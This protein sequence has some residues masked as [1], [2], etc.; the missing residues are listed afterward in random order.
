MNVNREDLVSLALGLLSAEEEV[1]VRAALN[2]DPALQ[3]AYSEDL[4]TLH[5]LPDSLPP[6]EVPEGA[7]DRL[8]ARVRAGESP[9]QAV[10]VEPSAPGPAPVQ[11]P[12]KP[13]RSLAPVLGALGL[14]AAL[15]AGVL[16]L[17]PAP[18][19]DLLGDFRAAPG[20]VVTALAP[21]DGAAAGELIRL[22]DGRAY[23]RLNTPAPAGR[24]Y[25]L[26]R[27]ENGQ[28]VSVGVFSGQEIQ[29][30]GAQAGQTVAVS[31]EPPGGSPQPTTTPLLVQ[32]L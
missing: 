16:L 14:A 30:Q 11:L 27:L 22:P 12:P 29:W 9:A 26:W 2:A 17:R 32:A 7:L 21:A 23:A 4:D 31:V 5:R 8:M 28:P 6:A 24:V 25:Q 1:R 10:Q 15:A 13:R 3:A 18:P 19:A 20:A